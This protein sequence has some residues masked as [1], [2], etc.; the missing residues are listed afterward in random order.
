MCIGATLALA[1]GFGMLFAFDPASSRVFP[2]CP[3][4]ALTGLY[5]P[6]CGSLRALHQLLQGHVK[7]AFALNALMVLFLP[8]VVYGL[9]AEGL[10]YFFNKKIPTV[11]MKPAWIWAIFAVII[12]YGIARNI[13]VYPFTVLAP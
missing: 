8:F 10:F 12:L 3:F 2:P 5:C 6:G 4:H 9:A 7:E 11:F 13:P 1:A